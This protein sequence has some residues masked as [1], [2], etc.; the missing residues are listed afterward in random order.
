MRKTLANDRSVKGL[1][2]RLYKE[3]SIF[4]YKSIIKRYEAQLKIGK[5]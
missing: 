3:I 2:P 4:S 5:G 1:V